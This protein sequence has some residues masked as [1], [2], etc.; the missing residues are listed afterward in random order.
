MKHAVL[1][2]LLV[3]VSVPVFAQQQK[4]PTLADF[5]ALAARMTALEAAL[6]A[7]ADANRLQQIALNGVATQAARLDIENDAQ[8]ASLAALQAGTVTP[9]STGVG[10]NSPLP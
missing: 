2:C 1:V 4:P 5:H 10:V 8:D 3:F 7:E 6:A 9:A